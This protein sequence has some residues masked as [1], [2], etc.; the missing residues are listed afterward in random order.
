MNILHYWKVSQYIIHTHTHTY[1]HIYIFFSCWL[2]YVY[3]WRE[4]SLTYTLPESIGLCS[5]KVLQVFS[6]LFHPHNMYYKVRE[7]D[8]HPK[9]TNTLLS[10]SSEHQ[11][12]ET[13]MFET[14]HIST[15]TGS[16][17]RDLKKILKNIWN[18]KEFENDK[19]KIKY[20]EFLESE[21]EATYKLEFLVWGGC[22]KWPHDDFLGFQSNSHSQEKIMFRVS[23]KKVF[24]LLNIAAATVSLELEHINDIQSL[25]VNGCIPASLENILVKYI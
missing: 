2:G 3:K 1:T 12:P 20:L 5:I 14:W 19:E 25:I 16:A 7:Y 13:R 18:T 15:P 8:G 21:I 24:S 22:D 9:K 17:P 6:S 10:V 11:K 4:S 23:K